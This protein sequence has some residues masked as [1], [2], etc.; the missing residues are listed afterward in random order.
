MKSLQ[1]FH[2]SNC[3]QLINSLPAFLQMSASSVIKDR[4]E[5]SSPDASERLRPEKSEKSSSSRHYRNNHD[6]HRRRHHRRANKRGRRNHRPRD[7]SP[8]LDTSNNEG[9]FTIPF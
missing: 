5:N 4:K 2:C 6:F 8:N 1:F 7:S 3:T 9:I